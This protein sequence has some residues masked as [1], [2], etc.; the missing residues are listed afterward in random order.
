MFL[1]IDSVEFARLFGTQYFTVQFNISRNK[2]KSKIDL[3]SVKG[4]SESARKIDS[5][6]GSSEREEEGK[7][8]KG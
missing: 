4:A 1:E 3:T 8:R 7:C 2:K 6:K 5:I